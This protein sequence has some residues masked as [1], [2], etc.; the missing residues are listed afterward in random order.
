MFNQI[1][2]CNQLSF[3]YAL[4]AALAGVSQA[5]SVDIF[6]NWNSQAYQ[7]NF[8]NYA[9]Q[10]FMTGV[11]SITLD[12]VSFMLRD[13]FGL[14][15]NYNGYLYSSSGSNTPASQLLALGNNT[16][17]Q[18]FDSNSG[19]PLPNSTISFTNIGY[20]LG[21]NTQYFIVLQ[22]NNSIGWKGPS[23]D[24]T[25]IATTPVTYY[26]LSSSN[27]TSWSTIGIATKPLAMVVTGTAVPEPS[28]MLL[29]ALAACV[30]IW[31]G[32]SRNRK[33]IAG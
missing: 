7:Y 14:S 10:S 22:S 19:T 25:S 18:W 31:A 21:P 33:T 13:E 4:I 26:S 28:T 12:S 30:T 20:Q 11:S 8:S 15:V 32:R 6:N 9:A 3:I 16:G 1:F 2:R 23:T 17:P 27:G 29:T 5:H 24:P